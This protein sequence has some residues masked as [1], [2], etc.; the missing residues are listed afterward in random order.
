MKCWLYATN[1]RIGLL[2][3]LLQFGDPDSKEKIALGAMTEGLLQE[4]AFG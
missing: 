3:I 1:K 2:E 4:F